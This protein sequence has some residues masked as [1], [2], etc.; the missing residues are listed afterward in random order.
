[1]PQSH[2]RFTAQFIVIVRVAFLGGGVALYET[3]HDV[4]SR[5]RDD[6][7][8]PK[9]MDRKGGNCLGDDENNIMSLR[10]G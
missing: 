6:P 5:V 4:D 2:T 7:F 3:A 9:Q 8:I 1:M 10:I